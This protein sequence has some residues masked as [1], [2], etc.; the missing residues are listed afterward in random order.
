MRTMQKCL[1]SFLAVSVIL[2]SLLIPMA[3]A[4]DECKIETAGNAVRIIPTNTSFTKDTAREFIF[5]VPEAG[6]YVV[7]FSQTAAKNDYTV[8]FTPTAGGETVLFNTGKTSEQSGNN[9]SYIRVGAAGGASVS[10]TLPAGECTIAIT[11]TVADAVINYIDIRC[12]TISVDGSKQAIYPSDYNAYANVGSSGHVNGMINNANTKVPG[13]TYVS[14]YNSDSFTAKRTD[15]RYIH[16]NGGVTVTYKLNVQK[17]G[18]YAVMVDQRFY[19]YNAKADESTNNRTGSMVLALDGEQVYTKSDTIIVKGNGGTT[20]DGTREWHIVNMALT[21]GPHEITYK[22]NTLG[23]YFYHFTIEELTEYNDKVVTVDNNLT[24]IESDASAKAIA[25]G[26]TRDFEFTVPVTG[27]YIFATQHPKTFSGKISATVRN[28]STLETTEIY[29]GTWADDQNSKYAKIGDSKTQPVMLE[30]GVAYELSITPDTEL[31]AD[32]V[33]VLRTEIPIDGKTAIP[34]QYITDSN[35]TLTHLNSD[36]TTGTVIPSEGYTL[37]GDYRSQEL[38]SPSEGTLIGVYM[39]NNGSYASYT[40]DVQTPGYYKFDI[41]AGHWEPEDLTGK[42]FFAINGAGFGSDTYSATAAV[43]ND[44]LSTPAIYLGTGKQTLTVT[45]KSGNGCGMYLKYLLAEP[46]SAGTGIVDATELPATVV[47]NLASDFTGLIGADGMALDN[48]QSISWNIETTEIAADLRL[49]SGTI[50]EGAQVSVKIDDAAA[51]TVLLSQLGVLFESKSFTA[52]THVLTIQSLTDG[53]V[54]GQLNLCEHKEPVQIAA[55]AARTKTDLTNGLLLSGSGSLEAAAGT[56]N[57]SSCYLITFDIADQG[58]YTVYVNAT[59]LQCSYKAYFDGVD[60]TNKWYYATGSNSTEPAKSAQ[61]KK[62]AVPMQLDAGQH[63]FILESL[64]GY[65]ANLSSQIELRRVDG[66][67]YADVSSGERVIPA[68]DFI[69]SNVT[70]DGWWFAHQYTQGAQMDKTAK[71]YEDF[72]VRNVVLD[73]ASGNQGWTY[74]VTVPEDGLYDFGFYH[75]NAS[76]GVR[77]TVDSNP[78]VIYRPTSASTVTKF[79]APEPLFLT[80]GTHTVTVRKESVAGTLRF[81]GLSFT[82]RSSVTVDE[83]SHSAQVCVGF[84]TAVT[85]K[86][87]TALYSGPEL[88]GISITDAANAKDV[89]VQVKNLSATPDSAKVMVWRDLDNVEPLMKNITFSADTQEW[90]DKVW[91]A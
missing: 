88:V 60:V 9:Y 18:N 47:P 71:G 78:E 55:G 51:E 33:D 90:V 8:T 1:S 59:I 83:T 40:L 45:N 77:V 62:L 25:A 87:V 4:A 44:T 36:D 30:V 5:T 75:S 41:A 69:S 91:F 27:S 19:S 28:Q 15:D 32:F 70:T 43:K 76:S 68:W 39:N 38:A 46:A 79:N 67:L 3:A 58:Y 42:L 2:M 13:Y 86:V 56:L 35:L 85:G 80:A 61:D 65:T 50:P 34:P 26:A 22:M 10:A 29:K 52:G 14:D 72:V 64:E 6:D 20:D 73:S 7:F 82:K 57:P 53:V 23:S 11:P 81:N 54:L 21:E 84:E 37:V 63:T 24:R 16:V 74:S 89:N 12:T 17:A 66:P 49:L 31:T 48:G